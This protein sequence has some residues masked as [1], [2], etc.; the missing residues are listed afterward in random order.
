MISVFV[1]GA[2]IGEDQTQLLQA[3]SE[4]INRINLKQIVTACSPRGGLSRVSSVSHT[5]E[6]K[7]EKKHTLIQ[8]GSGR[9]RPGGRSYCW[10]LLSLRTPQLRLSIHVLHELKARSWKKVTLHL[11][12][13]VSEIVKVRWFILIR[14]VPII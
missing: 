9:F 12:W 2:S 7:E 6:S 14:R 13:S 8:K 10:L 11:H 4:L 1:P 3:E 5:Q